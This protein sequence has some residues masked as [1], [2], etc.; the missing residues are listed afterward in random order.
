MDR[1][2]NIDNSWGRSIQKTYEF[3]P[4]A[5]KIIVE[6]A[7]VAIKL[8]IISFRELGYIFTAILTFPKE[9]WMYLKDYRKSTKIAFPLI[10]GLGTY[11]LFWNSPIGTPLGAFILLPSVFLYFGTS[12]FYAADKIENFCKK[13]EECFE[14]NNEV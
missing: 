9:R 8:A 2:E 7:K 13:A 12:F 10:F 3:D 5:V 14:I 6:T 11:F 1:V 4:K